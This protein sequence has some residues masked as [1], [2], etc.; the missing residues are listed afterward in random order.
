MVQKIKIAHGKSAA[1]GPDIG[2]LVLQSV[3]AGWLKAIKSFYN[4]SLRRERV[5]TSPQD[6]RDGVWFLSGFAAEQTAE[7]PAQAGFAKVKV[8]RG[9]IGAARVSREFSIDDFDYFDFEA[10]YGGVN[11]APDSFKGYSGGGLWQAPLIRGEDG[12]IKA[13]EIILSGVAFYETGRIANQN[14]IRC[15]GRCSVYRQVIDRV[16]GNVS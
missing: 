7:E 10:R 12:K 5:L 9:D 3:D 4:L 16:K 6:Y 8:F 11:Q 2:F 14:F 1:E 13:K 15:H